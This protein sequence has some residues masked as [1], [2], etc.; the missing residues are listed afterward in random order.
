LF[1]DDLLKIVFDLVGEVAIPHGLE[2]GFGDAEAG[3][4]GHVVEEQIVLEAEFLKEESPT[5][6][7]AVH[8]FIGGFRSGILDNCM[9]ASVKKAQEEI[10]LGSSQISKF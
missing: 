2:E 8:L 4:L 9:R 1:G 10:S 7:G 3:R 5:K 6:P